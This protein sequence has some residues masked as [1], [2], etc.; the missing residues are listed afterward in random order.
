MAMTSAARREGSG[1]RL[2][3]LIRIR[4]LAILGQIIAVLFVHYALGFDLLVMPCLAFIALSAWLNI[5]LRVR[6]PGN[7][8]WQGME[9]LGLLSYDIIQLASLLYLTGGLQNPFSI[10]LAV[11]V[12]VS[13]ATQKI[14]ET[15]FLFLLALGAASLLVFFHQPL[16]WFAGESFSLPLELK[17]GIWVALVSTMAFTS[18]YTFRVADES[19]KLVEAL[20]ATELVLQREQ[21]LSSLDGLATAAA[22][23]LGTPLATI[24]LVAKEMLKELPQASPIREDAE[25]LQSQAD[26]CRDILRKISSL[27]SEDD[28]NISLMPV[29]VLM[30]EIVQPHRDFGISV[31]TDA[32]GTPPVPV[33]RRNAAVLYGL[34]NLI[35]N[36]V[37]FARQTV[38]FNAEWTG[39]EVTFTITDDGPGFPQHVLERLGEPY[40][41]TRQGSASATGGGLGLGVFIAMTLL[42]RSGA[43]LAFGNLAGQTGQGARV[44][45]RW[46]RASFDH[47][48]K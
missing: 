18:V 37:D 8:R 34:G 9:V 29:N 12:T 21:H 44:V 30:E 25:L 3:T 11:P 39:E 17:A 19:R 14:R 48:R 45:I 43:T 15:V 31:E 46:P 20:A 24:S 41:S 23:E 27:S 38:V 33:L 22:H 28:T 36:A 10:L 2:E 47:G 13:A 32:R 1:L 7:L 35:E 16:P 40:F 26:R 42:E 5:F 6:Y 4:W